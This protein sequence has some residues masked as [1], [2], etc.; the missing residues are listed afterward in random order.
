MSTT[1]VPY[2]NCTQQ[3][4]WQEHCHRHLEQGTGP[5]PHLT[6]PTPR[7]RT[8]LFTQLGTTNKT[9]HV[10][11]SFK[12]AL[13]TVT[14]TDTA[15]FASA[16]FTYKRTTLLAWSG[17]CT[18]Y[19]NTATITETDQSA[20]ETVE[21]CVGK[22]LTVS[23]TAAGTFDR[24]YLWSIDKADGQD[25]GQV[26]RKA[27]PTT[28]RYTVDS[29]PDRH[30]R[31][32]LD[33]Q[34]QDHPSPTPTN[35]EDIMLTGITDVVDNGGTC[36][37]TDPHPASRTEGRARSMST[38]QLY[39]PPLEDPPATVART[40]PPVTW[41][42]AL[43]LHSHLIPLLA[44][45]TSPSARLETQTKLSMSPTRS[46]GALGEVTATDSDP[47]TKHTFNLRAH[48]F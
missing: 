37:V 33:T 24:T 28:L 40:P 11:N 16:S 15:P 36:T 4:Q 18:K 22:D 9:I 14:A 43:A 3:L 20:D 10:T 42:K 23:K 35:W 12:G 5:S 1:P 45:R 44:R 17:K 39:L 29:G 41:N 27:A 26:R 21:V 13:G 32:G 6:R 30:L 2:N 48:D 34:R 19:D 46:S 38:H 25:P 7:E 47:F 31:Q 8:S